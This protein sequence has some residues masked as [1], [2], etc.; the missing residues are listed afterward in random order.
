M[1][2]NNPNS[3]AIVGTPD[4][5][6]AVKVTD[7]LKDKT[8]DLIIIMTG[9]E[10]LFTAYDLTQRLRVENVGM[11]VPHVEIR[12]MVHQ[13]FNDTFCDE[14]ERTLTE[15]LTGD[16]SFVYHPENIAATDYHLAVK[17]AVDDTVD[18]GVGFGLTDS[19]RLN[20]P[21]SMLNDMELKKSDKVHIETENGVMSLTTVPAT[22]D[23]E[24]QVNA[25][26]RLRLNSTTLTRAFGSLS[27]K[28]NIEVS[29]D[30]TAITVR[31]I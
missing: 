4:M 21:L 18:D 15:L 2:S 3:V 6:V 30:K 5:G 24:L 31:P 9:K 1:D 17:P 13:E 8:I 25:D 28:Y 29:S 26:G 23:N 10:S 16:N 20:I 14:Y 11:N 12:D 19:N 27:K 22:P 7:T